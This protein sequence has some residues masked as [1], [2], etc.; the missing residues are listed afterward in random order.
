MKL[1]ELLSINLLEEMIHDG[2]IV[3]R[4]HRDWDLAILNYT[5]K[6][7]FENE[8]NPVT[9]Q[10]RGLIVRYDDDFQDAEVVARPFPKFFNYG[11]P[12][13]DEIGMDEEAWVSDKMDGSL[14]I[15]YVTPDGKLAIATRGSFHSEQAEWATRWLHENLH[16]E[17]IEHMARWSISYTD[18]F[19]IV[20]P[21]NRIVVDYGERAELVYLAS[22][23]TCT[24]DTSRFSP[25]AV[26]TPRA[27]LLAGSLREALALEPRENAEGVVVMTDDGRA[28]KLKQEDYLLK[29][30]ARFNL[31][32]K[33]IWEAIVANITLHDF[34][35]GMPD[36]FHDA[37]GKAWHEIED[38]GLEYASACAGWANQARLE[39]DRKAQAAYT[40][41][42]H[43]DKAAGIFAAL[44]GDMVKLTRAA[45]KYM[46]PTGPEASQLIA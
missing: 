23:H 26:P 44:D 42:R 14:G 33:R 18:L 4:W 15:A 43:P 24:G 3:R 37:I 25:S 28:V 7:Q 8:W 20:Y 31:T 36:E 9:R 13:A 35:E 2:Y 40:Q 27:E 29:H 39:G 38:K 22:V 19:E 1:S 16:P 12:G 46:E 30:R 32:P 5:D 21:E 10:C 6:A 41:L 11:Q 34:L 45:A 17:D